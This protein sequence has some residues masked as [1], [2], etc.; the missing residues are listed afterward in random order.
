M[1]PYTKTRLRPLRFLE[2]IEKMSLVSHDISTNTSNNSSFLPMSPDNAVGE[3]TPPPA[4]LFK[5]VKPVRRSFKPYILPRKKLV[6]VTAQ[7]VSTSVP[8]TRKNEE[9]LQPVPPI[10]SI[11]KPR[12][13]NRG[14]K[15]LSNQPRQ[16]SSTTVV[17]ESQEGIEN[18]S[19]IASEMKKI[20]EIMPQISAVL[21]NSALNHSVERRPH[22]RASAGKHRTRKVTSRENS[23]IVKIEKSNES[24]N[25]FLEPISKKGTSRPGSSVVTKRKAREISI[26]SKRDSSTKLE[27]TYLK[28][29]FVEFHKKSKNLLSELE[30]KVLGKNSICTISD[31]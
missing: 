2:K 5:R 16:R 30:R 9:I 31:I 25:S 21:N 17:K 19:N 10:E 22:S 6:P 24:L 12:H 27:L 29:Y 26:S 11:S 1:E 28:D 7:A 8:I 3:N 14:R 20:F 4:E 15:L 23:R 18:L 13:S